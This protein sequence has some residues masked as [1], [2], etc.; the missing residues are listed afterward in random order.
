MQNAP[1][2][3]QIKR[4]VREIEVFGITRGKLRREPKCGQPAPGVFNRPFSQVNAIQLRSRLS[5]A[6]MIRAQPYTNFQN[7][8]ILRIIKTRK[9]QDIRL[10]LIPFPSL[11]LVTVT[12]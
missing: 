7:S 9:F 5:E 11:G 2:I 4:L 10:Q 1:R 3:H 12:I 6:L 8:L